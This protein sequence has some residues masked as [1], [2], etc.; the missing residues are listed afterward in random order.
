MFYII[1]QQHKNLQITN[2]ISD[3]LKNRYPRT[4]FKILQSFKANLSHQSNT[5]FIINEDICLN[6]QLLEVVKNI[7]KND[8][9]VTLSLF[10]KISTT[11]SY[12]APTLTSWKSLIVTTISK[13][14]FV[15]VLTS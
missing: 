7:R 3:Y 1:E 15:I 14:K 5:Y 8:Q 12:S 10:Q 2:I 13:K 4:A 11:N 6:E 9:L